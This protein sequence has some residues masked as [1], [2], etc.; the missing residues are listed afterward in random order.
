ML[1]QP[2]LFA[3]KLARGIIPVVERNDKSFTA[4]VRLNRRVEES[5]KVVPVSW[6]QEQVE[7]VVPPPSFHQQNVAV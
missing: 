5:V 1:D 7:A 4:T 2:R 3:Q 6:P